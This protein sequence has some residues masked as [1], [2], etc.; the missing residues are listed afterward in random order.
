MKPLKC[1]IRVLSNCFQ[2]SFP[3]PNK[4]TLAFMVCVIKIKIRSSGW[5]KAI[6]RV[7]SSCDGVRQTKL[8][9]D[10]KVM[11]S[12]IVD[13]N[14]LMKN[15]AKVNKSA[16][17]EWIQ[18]GQCSTNLF[19]PPKPPTNNANLPSNQGPFRNFTYPRFG[20]PPHHGGYYGLPPPLRPYVPFRGI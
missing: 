19:L 17:L 10:G 6:T 11:V 18:F 4:A 2:P 14:L 9:E 12:G 20:P 7:L 1:I 5:Q 13:P 3:R 15:L 8:T 16:E